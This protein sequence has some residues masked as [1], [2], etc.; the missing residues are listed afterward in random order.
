[1]PSFFQTFSAA[2]RGLFGPTPGAGLTPDQWVRGEDYASTV[3]GE[4][5]DPY[6]QS[7]WVWACIQALAGQVGQ[8]PFKISRGKRGGPEVEGGP[9]WELLQH[10][11]EQLDRFAFWELATAWFLLRGECFFVCLDANDGVVNLTQRGIGRE[12]RKLAILPPDQMVP[13]I[14]G[15]TLQGWRFM[16]STYTSP[17]A[18]QWLLP[19][20]LIHW[21]K[22]NPYNWFRGV[23]PLSAALLAAKTDYATAQFCKGLMMN[24]ADMGLIV[25]V[26][27]NPSQEQRAQI[28]SALRER[29]RKAGTADRP[30]LLG[31]GAKIEKPT[32]AA[33]DMEVLAQRKFSR[34][35]ICAAFGV[36][37]E[38]LG[39]S[40]DA[41]RA[42]SASAFSGFIDNTVAPLLSRAESALQPLAR[43]YS[44]SAAGMSGTLVLWFAVDSIP[45]RQAR[46][47]TRFVTAKD[48][49]QG[50]GIPLSVLNVAFDLDLP[51]LPHGDNIYLPVTLEQVGVL[52]QAMPGAPAPQ[53]PADGGDGDPESE[54]DPGETVQEAFKR[55]ARALPLLRTPSSAA[56]PQ[57][58]ADAKP[59]VA[60]RGG[61]S[62]AYL[63]A[64]K[65]SEKKKKGFLRRFFLD[66]K[67]RVLAHLK[68]NTKSE[69]SDDLPNQTAEDALLTSK[70]AK[71]LTLDIEFGGAQ[72]AAELGIDFAMA[73]SEALR[74]LA[75][76]QPKIVGINTTTWDELKAT[77]S[78]GI[79]SGEGFEALAQRVSEVFADA[80]GRRAEVIALTE[81]NGAINTGRMIAM[82]EAGI[83]H[84]AWITSHLEN[85][86]DTHL[87]C[88]REG[89]IP[90][91]D[92]FEANG[93]SY[94]GDPSGPAH[95]VINCRCHLIAATDP[96]GAEPALASMRG[97]RMSFSAFLESKGL[98]PA[99]ASVASPTP[100]TPSQPHPN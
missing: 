41:N 66:Q 93:L 57:A 29:K 81:T 73:P 58:A 43:C 50:M 60:A 28:L 33:A 39:F 10:P 69:A 100:A 94:P 90:I 22:P 44:G 15:H 68:A 46:R 6:T 2:V 26:E 31:G 70:F 89:P 7:V 88:E 98:G 32:V 51:A 37:Q 27:G 23:A 17:I 83:T 62:H 45:D 40:E 20:E 56:P 24:N 59:Q 80:V 96:D 11:H 95:E 79:A 87:A 74:Y 16:G 18:S 53:E 8:V 47:R 30:I 54:V 85:T 52:G 61:V 78:E 72:L 35:E 14:D 19:E 75:V 67:A 76:R 97:T 63:A 3:G 82:R 84:K 13:V 49:F 12:I 1:M 92:L 42:V 36:N 77:L 86:R 71:L 55:L 91:D 99:P 48:V 4:L 65:G 21:K 25:S 5:T 38:V 9:L 34:Q 64:I